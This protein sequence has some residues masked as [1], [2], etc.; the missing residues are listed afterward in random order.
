MSPSTPGPDAELIDYAAGVIVRSRKQP[1]TA[2]YDW[3]RALREEGML[4]PPGAAH[5]LVPSEAFVV[6]LEDPND[7]AAPVASPKRVAEVLSRALDGYTF[8]LDNELEG[9]LTAALLAAGVFRD[10][11]TVKAEAV[12]EFVATAGIWPDDMQVTIGTVREQ[13]AKHSA[14]L[15]AGNS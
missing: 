7:S 1:H 15:R 4:V 11:A 10:E 9:Q 8:D 14:A 5:R 6:P 2:P 3:A 13:G 12:E